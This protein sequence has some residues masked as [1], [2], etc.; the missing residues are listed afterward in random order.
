MFQGALA[1]HRGDREASLLALSRSLAH[2]EV[3]GLAMH[4]AA[5]R[6]RIGQMLG[7]ERGRELVSAGDAF[8]ASQTV[9]N[10]EATTELHCPGYRRMLV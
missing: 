4:V 8:M 2:L 7:G 1:A 10:L 9:V 6:R 5:A 3:D